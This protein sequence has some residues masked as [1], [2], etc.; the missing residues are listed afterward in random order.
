M[1][2]P[3]KRL[4][5]HLSFRYRIPFDERLQHVKDAGFDVVSAWWEEEIEEARRFRRL[6][7]ELIR[8]AGLELDNIHVP[9]KGCPRLWSESASE[10]NDSVQQH[11]GWVNDCARHAIPKMVMHAT[12]SQ[13]TP[14]NVHGIDSLNRIVAAAEAKG[15]LVAIENTRNSEQ[16]DALF[17]AIDSPHLGLCYDV[18]HDWL[19][20]GEPFALLKKWAHRLAVTHLADTDGRLDR[21]WLP[22]EGEIDFAR[23]ATALT[24]YDGI[25]IL[26]VVPKDR[27]EEVTLFLSRARNSLS[28]VESGL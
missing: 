6:A 23:L 24:V 10:R 14:L 18:S 28:L 17:D 21:H 25:H 15:V 22:G 26:E 1:N 3:A 12:L 8:K 5:I 19:Y 7:P 4:G 9:Y 20:T 13:G 11:I 2:I 16:L 27:S